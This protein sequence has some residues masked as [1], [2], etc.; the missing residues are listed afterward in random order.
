[1][2]KK[3]QENQNEVNNQ[4]QID[5]NLDDNQDQIDENLDDNQDDKISVNLVKMIRG[6]EYPEPHSAEVHPSEVDNFKTSGWIEE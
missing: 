1:M 6:N 3:I 4:D 5:E 2:N